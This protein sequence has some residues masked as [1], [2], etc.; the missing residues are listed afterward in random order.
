VILTLIGMTASTPIG[1]ALALAGIVA[2]AAALA[3]NRLYRARARRAADPGAL[4]RDLRVPARPSGRLGVDPFWRVVIGLVLFQAAYMAET[5]R[6]LQSVSRAQ[7]EAAT[8]LWPRLLA[9]PARGHPAAGS[10]R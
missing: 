3:R 4:R 10:S 2:R 1:V 5:V 9:D 6:R 8:S 7:Y